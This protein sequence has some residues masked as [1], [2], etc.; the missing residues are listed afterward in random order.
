[1]DICADRAV[2]L[3]SAIILYED[4]DFKTLSDLYTNSRIVP[5]LT[6]IDGVRAN[7]FLINPR[8]KMTPIMV[9]QQF[10]VVVVFLFFFTVKLDATNS[11]PSNTVEVRPIYLKMGHISNEI[12]QL[13]AIYT[14]THIPITRMPNRDRYRKS[15]RGVCGLK[16]KSQ[17]GKQNAHRSKV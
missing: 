9:N 13:N 4:V 14:Y 12:L 17:K 8:Q 10:L 5:F 6:Y 11:F 1:M 7:L 16:K 2:Q 15:M 3:I